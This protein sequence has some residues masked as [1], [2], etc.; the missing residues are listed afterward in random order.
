MSVYPSIVNRAVCPDLQGR[1]V[2]NVSAGARGID[3]TRGL[4]RNEEFCS[5]WVNAA[6]LLVVALATGHRGSALWPGSR[7][8]M[9]TFRRLCGTAFGDRADDCVDA[10]STAAHCGAYAECT[11][12]RWFMVGLVHADKPSAWGLEGEAH[13]S[14]AANDPATA[15]G[16]ARETFNVDGRGTASAAEPNLADPPPPSPPPPPTP[17]PPPPPPPLPLPPLP[18]LPGAS[19]CEEAGESISVEQS[20]SKSQAAMED[21]LLNAEML[22]KRGS[23]SGLAAIRALYLAVQCHPKNLKAWYRFGFLLARHLN[24]ARGA[25]AAL[26]HAIDVGEQIGEAKRSGPAYAERAIVELTLITTSKSEAE[27]EELALSAQGYMDRA[28]RL[29][30]DLAH[31]AVR[32]S[33]FA[34]EIDQEEQGVG[35]TDVLAY[36]RR[37]ASM[38]INP[39]RRPRHLRLHGAPPQDKNARDRQAMLELIAVRDVNMMRNSSAGEAAAGAAQ[40]G[41]DALKAAGVKEAMPPYV[42]PLVLALGAARMARDASDGGASAD[43]PAGA[44]AATD[45]A[46]GAEEARSVA[47]APVLGIAP[48]ANETALQINNSAEAER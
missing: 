21:Y 5:D 19:A 34:R 43:E 7:A 27:V 46:A 29:N 11:R 28:R 24:C 39:S 47:Q 6:G 33:S 10:L 37:I 13:A 2:F 25:A 42:D 41:I 45:A 38:N 16:V 35:F 17:P 23:P 4:S 15:G 32:Y 30:P 26:E 9:A 20:L 1:V 31:Q 3:A 48:G 12:T 22:G 18:P 14:A 36:A 40:V 44:G 8:A